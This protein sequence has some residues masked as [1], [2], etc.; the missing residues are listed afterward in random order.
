MLRCSRLRCSRVL[1]ASTGDS[2]VDVAAKPVKPVCVD[3]LLASTGDGRVGRDGLAS[4]SALSRFAVHA[5]Q[6][7]ADS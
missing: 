2:T 3:G 7:Q 5:F 1:E 6:M 4:L